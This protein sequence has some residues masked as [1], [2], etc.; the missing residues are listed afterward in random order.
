MTAKLGAKIEAVDLVE[1]KLP[2]FFSQTK[3][4]LFGFLVNYGRGVKRGSSACYTYVYSYPF[5]RSVHPIG[6][7][8]IDWVSPYAGP[9]VTIK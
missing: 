7:Y 5:S 2:T 9:Y 6:K 3:G 4:P 8:H 1:A